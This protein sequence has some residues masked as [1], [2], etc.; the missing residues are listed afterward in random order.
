MILKQYGLEI[1]VEYQV[2][3]MPASR[4][5]VITPVMSISASARQLLIARVEVDGHELVPC[6]KI[7]AEPGAFSIKLRSMRIVNPLSAAGYRMMLEISP[8]PGIFEIIEQQISI[9]AE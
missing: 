3:M 6:V 1:T 2:E 9:N 5:A 8:A 4:I 7:I